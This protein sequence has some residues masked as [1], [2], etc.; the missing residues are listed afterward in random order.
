MYENFFQ[1]NKLPFGM[2]PDPSCLLMTESHREALS[3]L[4]Y[5]ISARKG[6]SV[7]TG[8]AGTGKTTLLRALIRS[9]TS[10][11]FSVILNPTL[12]IKDFLELALLDF[13][14]HEVPDSKAQRIMKLQ[15][16]L[17]K[18]Y[19][20]G[21]PPVLII[22]EAHKL[23]PEILEEIRLLTNF[24]TSDQKLLQIVLAGQTEL[25]ALLNREDLRQL[26]QRIEIRLEVKPLS[27]PEVG[28]YM[29]HRW[30]R[31]G[32]DTLPFTAGAIAA[33]ASASHGIP[34]L[35]NSICDNA[36]LTAFG[37]EKRVVGVD[38]IRLVLRD[39]D[40][41]HSAPVTTNGWANASD[42]TWAGYAAPANVR[43]AAAAQRPRP[44]SPRPS[45]ESP[46]ALATA[47][48]EPFSMPTIERYNNPPSRMGW[49]RRLF[50]ASQTVRT[51]HE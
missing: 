27:S 38:H 17:V 7:L 21:I 28:T 24:E 44:A 50:G 2:T 40:M 9:C 26:K 35:I 22:D 34:R 37:D 49:V 10:A 18:L 43:P 16:F 31:A 3:G 13:G 46:A 29:M 4:I 39:L 25:K 12:S 41:E 11:R 14:I 48:L 20:A 6:F 23:S 45:F 33:V 32:G 51:V 1:L 8:D 47:N 15:D 5:T 42:R 19:E 30:A 36:L